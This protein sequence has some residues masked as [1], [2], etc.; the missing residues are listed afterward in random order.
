MLTLHWRQVVNKLW[1]VLCTNAKCK[2]TDELYCTEEEMLEF[3]ESDE[4]SKCPKCSSP[5]QREWAFG[6]GKF[7]SHGFTRRT[8]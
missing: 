6:M 2:F 5:L 7:N 8:T 3:F 4:R 1:G